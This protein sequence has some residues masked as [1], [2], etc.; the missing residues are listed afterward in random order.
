MVGLAGLEPAISTFMRRVCSP[1]TPQ[2]LILDARRGFD[3]RFLDPKSSVRPLDERA[4]ILVAVERFE[5][6]LNGV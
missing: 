6:S 3:P 2:A 1:I 5:L 4:K